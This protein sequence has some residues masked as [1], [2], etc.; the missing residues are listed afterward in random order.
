[1]FQ[2]A[3]AQVKDSLI[4]MC[5]KVKKV[6]LDKADQVYISMQRDYMTLVGV[7]MDKNHVMP[8]QE[9]M[10]RRAVEESIVQ[11]DTCFQEVLNYDDEAL[12]ERVATP[13]QPGVEEERD[14]E[15]EDGDDDITFE[16]SGAEEEL[17]EDEVSGEGNA[18]EDADDDDSAGNEKLFMTPGVDEGGQVK[19]EETD[20]VDS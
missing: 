5:D 20:G 15:M 13:K 10:K 18:V 8:R 6:M 3:T 17:D 12:R 7:E 16:E 2:D 11:S 14:V 9:R 19:A 1:M 4:S